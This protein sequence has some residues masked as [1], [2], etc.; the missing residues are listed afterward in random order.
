VKKEKRNFYM[1]F[2]LVIYLLWDVSEAWAI[3]LT[4][5]VGEGSEI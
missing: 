4:S 2:L 3:R 5:E 1:G